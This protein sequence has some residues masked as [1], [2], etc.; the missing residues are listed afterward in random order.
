MV[1]RGV[2]RRFDMPDIRHG[3]VNPRYNTKNLARHRACRFLMDA[4]KIW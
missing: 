1:C 4:L 3:I 2:R